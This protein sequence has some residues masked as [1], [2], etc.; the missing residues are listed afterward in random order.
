MARN[1]LFAPEANC[2]R[3]KSGDP[4]GRAV[5]ADHPKR[6]QTWMEL[7]MRSR[8][9]GSSTGSASGTRT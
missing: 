5:A 9:S 6:H 3:A 2:R 8:T 4:K 1:V 7:G